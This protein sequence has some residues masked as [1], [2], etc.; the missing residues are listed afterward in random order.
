MLS[1]DARFRQGDNTSIDEES[2]P[3]GF[4]LNGCDVRPA[5]FGA[6]GSLLGHDELGV[7]HRGQ[8]VDGRLLPGDDATKPE[9]LDIKGEVPDQPQAAPPGGQHR[10]PEGGIVQPLSAF[11]NDP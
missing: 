9:A 3:F 8:I 10:L 11:G 2:W 6:L 5:F 4:F 7:L 1:R